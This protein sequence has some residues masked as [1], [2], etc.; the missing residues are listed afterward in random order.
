M[1][2]RKLRAVPPENNAKLTFSRS[3]VIEGLSLCI[4]V[5]GACGQNDQNTLTY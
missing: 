5:G 2:A 1:A 3:S 4:K